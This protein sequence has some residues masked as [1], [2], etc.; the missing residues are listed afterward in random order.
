MYADLSRKPPE[1]VPVTVPDPDTL[2][3]LYD[4]DGKTV[5]QIA[6]LARCRPQTI[7]AAMEAAGIARRRR[8]RRRAP[9]PDIDPETLAEIARLGGRARARAVARSLGINREKFDLLIGYRLGNRGQIETQVLALRDAEIR[10]AYDA[11][12]AV[13]ELAT[14]YGCTRRAISRSLDRTT[15][16]PGIKENPKRTT[17]L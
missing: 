7:L 11:G 16:T 9:L 10:A 14:H 8:G 5:R 15:P 13:N 3:A 6:A 4:E 12:V 1:E 17:S 2:R